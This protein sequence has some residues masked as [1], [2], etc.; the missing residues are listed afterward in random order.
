MMPGLGRLNPSSRTLILVDNDDRHAISEYL[1]ERGLATVVANDVDHA[2]R[3]A[4]DVTVALLDVSRPEVQDLAHGFRRYRPELALVTLTEER[5]SRLATRML[6]LDVEDHFARPFDLE[7]L[8]WRLSAVFT[9]SLGLKT[10][11]TFDLR[12]DESSRTVYHAGRSTRLT[13]SEYRLVTTLARKPGHV[14]KR[15]DVIR[16][17]WGSDSENGERAVD[18]LVSRTR[19]HLHQG[20]GLDPDVIRT[21]RGVGYQL[22]RRRKPRNGAVG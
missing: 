16:R 13:P 12:F 5:D 4:P 22:E 9:A 3:L 2:I 17:V 11:G 15:H 19:R 18:A 21:V 6:D 10:G 1:E 8:A 7:M 20:V 14:F